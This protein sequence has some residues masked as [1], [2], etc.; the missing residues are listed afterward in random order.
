MLCKPAAVVLVLLPALPC[1]ADTPP[2]KAPAPRAQVL[3]TTDDTRSLT[4]AVMKLV[5]ADKIDDAFGQLKLYWQL[6]ANELDTVALKTIAMRNTVAERF[7]RPQSYEL[8]REETAGDFLVRYTYAERR[9]HHPLRWTF[10]F[11]RTGEQWTMDAATWVD[12]VMGFF[13]K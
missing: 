9:E 13:T 10:V 7:G 8:V 2:A 3:K 6:P 11:Y 12:N 5:V 1:V 4:D